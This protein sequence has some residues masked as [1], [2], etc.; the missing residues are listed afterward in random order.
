[1]H[2]DAIAKAEHSGLGIH[3]RF[4]LPVPFTRQQD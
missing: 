4:F 3:Q 1:V 2:R